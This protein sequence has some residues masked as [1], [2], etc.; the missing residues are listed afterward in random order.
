MLPKQRLNEGVLESS[1]KTQ[2][3]YREHSGGSQLNESLK[4]YQNRPQDTKN[5]F[6][7]TAKT[8][9]FHDSAN[10]FKHNKLSRKNQL[11]REIVSAMKN[12]LVKNMSFVWRDHTIRLIIKN[13][14]TN[15]K[16]SQSNDIESFEAEGRELAAK[17]VHEA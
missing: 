17:N 10:N 6:G 16:T 5:K 13:T 9:K 11:K 15:Q 14:V 7:Q 1:H 12:R 2:R 8:E 4:K 3:Y